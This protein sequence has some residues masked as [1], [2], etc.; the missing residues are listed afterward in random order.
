M[1]RV[2]FI[3]Y[4]SKNVKE[5]R[6]TPVVI[7]IQ[8]EVCRASL[9]VVI[10]YSTLVY[11][12]Y[13]LLPTVLIISSKGHPSL[14]DCEVNI[15]IDSPFKR[16]ESKF[17]AQDCSLF[18]PGTVSTTVNSKSTCVLS[19]LCESISHQNKRLYFLHNA[20]R[21]SFLLTCEVAMKKDI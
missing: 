5:D 13:K 18:L 8:K 3:T 7:S 10:R 15:D 17:W 16:I 6:F 12:K 21:Q 19:T 9:L 2:F 11:E 20:E 1:M 4:V 14:D